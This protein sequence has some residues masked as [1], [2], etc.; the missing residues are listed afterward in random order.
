MFNPK[1]E[2]NINTID[3]RIHVDEW[4]IDEPDDGVWMSLTRRMASIS[5]E[6]TKVEARELA[7][8]LLKVVDRA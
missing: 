1:Y 7:A 2:T 3:A 5:V 8:A 6:L 4:T